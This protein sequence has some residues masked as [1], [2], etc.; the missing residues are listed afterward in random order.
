MAGKAK[1]KNYE[2]GDNLGL[3]LGKV[4]E[5]FLIP[6]L[7]EFME[8]N[9]SPSDLMRELLVDHFKR[10]KGLVTPGIEEVEATI[11][12]MAETCRRAAK[13]ELASPPVTA[14]E[15]KL[16][17]EVQKTLA[18][19]GQALDEIGEDLADW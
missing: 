19:H 10:K 12:W 14:Q 2:A 15:V 16:V 3:R 8:E 7:N 1:R 17:R 5:A 4:D 9:G 6:C 11:Q 18:E 13:G